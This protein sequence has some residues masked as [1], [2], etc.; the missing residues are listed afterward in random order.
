M[1]KRILPLVLG[2]ILLLSACAP[3]SGIEVSDAWARPALQGE[4]GA[5]YFV[6]QNHDSET[7]E[8]VGIA[9][10]V[11]EA[12]ELHESMMSGDVMQMHPLESVALE[13]GTQV[14]FEP[15]GLHVM[16]VGLKK[17][18]AAGDE[19]EITLKFDNFEDIRI[20][21]PVGEGPVHQEDR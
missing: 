9:S 7:H 13:P 19:F 1:M 17:A 11:A 8:M 2:S 20:T 10:D 21:V 3:Q 18:L 15:G 16:L 5:V 4:N 6:V 12:V 14:T